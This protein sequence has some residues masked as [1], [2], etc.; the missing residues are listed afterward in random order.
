[1]PSPQDCI[2]CQIVAGA[3]PSTIVHEDDR[4]LAFMN[5]APAAP[6]HL[7]V[8]PKAHATD[9]L[10]VPSDDLAASARTAQRMAR[11]VVGVL[12]A[13]GVNLVHATRPVAGQTVFHVHLHVLPRYLDDTI[14]GMWTPTPGDPNVIRSVGKRLRDAVERAG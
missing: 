3:A 8:I 9:L 5:I 11:R 2:F 1:M 14:Q 12:G 13:D 4:T 10:D 7:L 6:G